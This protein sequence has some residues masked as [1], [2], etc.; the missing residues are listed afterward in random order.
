VVPRA[1]TIE[2]KGSISLKRLKNSNLKHCCVQFLAHLRQFCFSVQCCFQCHALCSSSFAIEMSGGYIVSC[3]MCSHDRTMQDIVYKLVPACR[4]Q[5]Y[6]TLISC[7]CI[8]FYCIVL[9]CVMCSH[10]RT[11]QDIVYK[12]VPHLQQSQLFT[13]HTAFYTFYILYTAVVLYIVVS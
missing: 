4:W 13:H 6:H 5:T 8:V 9:C 10:D 12:L 1:I 2:A 7:Y 3:V 11:M